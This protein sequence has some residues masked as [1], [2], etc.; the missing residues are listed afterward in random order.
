MKPTMST[1]L[2]PY[3]PIIPLILLELTTS[4]VNSGYLEGVVRGY[5]NSLLTQNNYHT[6][7]QCEN[8]EGGYYHAGRVCGG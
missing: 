3:T 4:Q 5:K 6:L 2:G 1:Q 7:T 8:L